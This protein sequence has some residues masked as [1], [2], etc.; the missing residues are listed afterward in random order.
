VEREPRFFWSYQTLLRVYLNVP[1]TQGWYYRWKDLPVGRLQADPAFLAWTIRHYVEQP[2]HRPAIGT[3]A[4]LTRLRSVLA[5]HP[6]A[7][8]GPV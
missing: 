7:T 4:E 5:P 6:V 1:P 2:W 3:E 8:P